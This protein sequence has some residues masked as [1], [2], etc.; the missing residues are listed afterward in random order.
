MNTYCPT[1]VDGFDVDII[2]DGLE[3]GSNTVYKK[4][5][6]NNNNLINLYFLKLI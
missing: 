2:S 5:N 6:Y 3:S 4:A 1:Q